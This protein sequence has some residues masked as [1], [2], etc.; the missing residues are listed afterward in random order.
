MTL[1]LY[2]FEKLDH[3][4][5]LMLFDHAKYNKVYLR[6]DMYGTKN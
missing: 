6:R 2:R 5:N 1:R 4:I 3:C